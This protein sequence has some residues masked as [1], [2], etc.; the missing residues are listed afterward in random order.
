MLKDNERL[1]ANF[2]ALF[3]VLLTIGALVL[4]YYIRVFTV[5]QKIVYSDQYITLA[6]LIIPIWYILIN[7]IN[8]QSIQ[9]V[10]TYSVVFFEYAL[11]VLIGTLLLFVFIFLLKLD[12]ISRLAVLIFAFADLILLFT[13]RVLIYQRLKKRRLKGKGIKNA[14]LVADEGSISF[15]QKLITQKYLGFKIIAI[16]SDSEKVKDEFG[17]R[18][19]VMPADANI[20]KML[21][22]KVIDELIYCKSQADNAQIEELIHTSSV[23]GVTFQLQ[24]D[25]FS[26]IASQAHLNYYGQTPMM[27]FANTPSDYLA[28]TVKAVFEYIFSLI[29]LALFSPFFLIIALAVRLESKGPVLF[30]QKRVGL[31]GRL[32]TMYKFRTMVNDAEKLRKKLEDKNEADGPV[33]KIKDDPRVTKVGA[34]LR[35]TSLDEIPQFLN[36]LKGDMAVVGP[37]PPVPEEVEQYTRPQRRRLSMKPGITCIWQVSGRNEI[38][39]EDWMKM[40]LQY[41][42]NWSLKL[43]FLLMLKT[44]NAVFRRTGY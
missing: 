29:F 40:D 1:Y 38:A 7:I 20:E 39:F 15:I 2:F 4:G 44:V 26:F 25:F 21:E 24:S 36:V 33:F 16:V 12:N 10:K 17:G 3:D 42:D 37:R 8:F 5:S 35:K 19:N 14:L 23:L 41:I 27:T 43:D 9:K 22:E 6:L 28:L 13:A 31:R 32:F 34:F 18:F 11:V 30:K